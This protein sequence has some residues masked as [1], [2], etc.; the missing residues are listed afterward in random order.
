MA[1]IIKQV[2]YLSLT[3]T[4][5]TADRIGPVGSIQINI[6]KE[7]ITLTWTAPYAV[8]NTALNDDIWYTILICKMLNSSSVQCRNLNTT[9]T[10]YIFRSDFLSPCQNY[11]FRVIPYNGSE[12]GESSQNVT[13]SLTCN[14]GTCIHVYST[15]SYMTLIGVHEM[16]G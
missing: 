8:D 15:C 2:P 14:S 7:A 10:H 4:L 3:F 9:E 1:N 6:S 11:T 12:Q 16:H 5:L 13:G